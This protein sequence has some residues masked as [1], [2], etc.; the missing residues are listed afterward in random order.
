MYKLQSLPP[1]GPELREGLRCRGK[2]PADSQKP[3]QN[4]GI[5]IEFRDWRKYFQEYYA[6][7][8][9]DFISIVLYGFQVDITQ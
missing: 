8:R 6:V 4:A 9:V 2:A 3:A 7:T 1:L 5:I